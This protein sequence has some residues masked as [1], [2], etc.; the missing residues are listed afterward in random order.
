MEPEERVGKGG[1]ELGGRGGVGRMGGKESRQGGL[2]G[3]KA[4]REHGE[5]IKTV[6]VRDEKKN[7]NPWKYMMAR[8]PFKVIALSLLSK[9]N[10]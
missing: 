6:K 1:V 4:E 7:N 9:I 2:E 10:Q 8:P 3:R 5:E